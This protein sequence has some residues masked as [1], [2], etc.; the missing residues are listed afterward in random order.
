M[1]SKELREKISEIKLFIMDVDGTLTDGKIYLTSDGEEI[2]AFNVKDGI[3]IKLLQRYGIIPVIITGRISKIVNIRAKEL[4]ICEIYQGVEYKLEVYKKLKT[5]YNIKDENIVYIGDDINDLEIFKIVGL[6]F[7]V[8]D[9]VEEIR[10]IADY[11]TC[12]KGGEGA[13]REAIECI[14][15]NQV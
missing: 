15:K 3:G 1:I 4:D 5:K 13:V 10:K 9:A 6:K 2:K 11:V 12:A 14:I 8:N 7:A